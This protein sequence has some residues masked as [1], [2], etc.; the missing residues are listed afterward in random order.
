MDYKPKIKLSQDE[1]QRA[2]NPVA[3]LVMDA[4]GD[5]RPDRGHFTP[6][7]PGHRFTDVGSD[8]L[9]GGHHSGHDRAKPFEITQPHLDCRE[10]AA[11]SFEAVEDPEV[12]SHLAL[13]QG[14]VLEGRGDLRE[15][16]AAFGA[17]ASLSAESA[18]SAARL[19]RG[20]GEWRDAA[21]S[22]RA[23]ATHHSGAD[24]YG[25]VNVLEQRLVD[26]FVEE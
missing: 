4:G 9:P 15:A 6:G 10:V 25:L 23:F 3:R 18:L 21:D 7:H 16:A 14:R 12:R 22:L 2:G 17:A 24:L 5:G 19:L 13:V 26:L 1:E 11:Q 20:L 8:F